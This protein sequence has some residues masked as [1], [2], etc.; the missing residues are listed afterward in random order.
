MA[1]FYKTGG[2]GGGVSSDELTG[3]LGDV[4][5][6][7]TVV[8][9]DTN[10]EIGTGTLELNGDA[11]TD[12]VVASKTYYTTDPKTKNIGTLADKNGTTQSAT[13]TLD[14]TNSRVVMPVPETGRYDTS[15][16]LYAAYSVIAS[17]IGLT[18]S[19][20]VSGNTILGVPG[21]ATGDAT[22]DSAG[23]ML[24]GVI[25]YGKNGAKYIGNIASLAGGTKTPTTSQQTI[26]CKNK[27]MTSDIVIPA[28]ALPSASIIAKGKTVT[29]YG[30]KVTGTYEGYY[31]GTLDVYNRGTWGSGYSVSN[32]KAYAD[33]SYYETGETDSSTLTAE[34]AQ[35]KVLMKYASTTY[36]WYTM[37]V[38]GFKTASNSLVNFSAYKTLNIVYSYSKG[39]YYYDDFDK[40][41]TFKLTFT[42]YNSSGAAIK[43]VNHISHT[44]NDYRVKWE[45]GSAERTA[46]I[47]ISSYNG[48]G[49]FN[50]ELF[51]ENRENAGNSQPSFNHTAYIQRIYFTA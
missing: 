15:S 12:D 17:L 14:D 47:D 48:M 22:L 33:D 49:G 39:Y 26:S 2:A 31:A 50:I 20:I 24:N 51:K 8:A 19:K 7:V 6:G 3:T 36:G 23:D 34:T 40:I 44:E 1:R 11:G 41:A 9:S 38:G 46:T 32:F 28:F 35:L 30:K 16:K 29:I 25:G 27:Y 13:P 18:G 45:Q 5:K 4:I 21:T 37:S 10:D 42:A 43:S